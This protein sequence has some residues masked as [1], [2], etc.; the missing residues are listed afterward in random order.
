MRSWTRSIA[1]ALCLRW[2]SRGAIVALLLSAVAVGC[3]TPIAPKAAPLRFESQPEAGTGHM[4]VL[5][6]GPWEEYVTDL[7]PGFTLKPDDAL[8]QAGPTT[9]AMERKLLDML[10]VVARVA[11][12]STSV[13]STRTSTSDAVTDETGKTT[14]TGDVKNETID[15]KEPGTAPD[16]TPTLPGD[17]SAAA[18]DGIEEITGQK[19]ALGA[20]ALAQYNLATALMQEVKLLNRY[21]KDATQRDGYRPYLVRM[22]VSL[23]PSVRNA[24]YDAYSTISFFPPEDA[25]ALAGRQALPAVVPLLV[26]DDME[27]ALT[28]DSAELVRQY[29]LAISALI[30]GFAARGEVEKYT[31][32]LVTTIARDFNSLYSVARQTDNSIRVRMGARL[33]SSRNY[34]MVPQTHNITLLLLA[35][36]SIPPGSD[37]VVEG[38][39]EFVDVT[40]GQPIHGGGLSRVESVVDERLKAFKLDQYVKGTTKSAL[41]DA[42]VANDFPAFDAVLRPVLRQQRADRANAPEKGVR[43]CAAL[44]TPPPAPF[45]AT[46]QSELADARTARRLWNAFNRSAVGARY[47]ST[48]FMLP[49]RCECSLPLPPESSTDATD[50]GNTNLIVDLRPVRNVRAG[51]LAGRL[52]I[53]PLGEAPFTI[54]ASKVEFFREAEVLRCT[55]PSPARVKHG[56]KLV[57]QI[58]LADTPPVVELEVDGSCAACTPCSSGKAERYK[59]ELVTVLKAPPPG[60]AAVKIETLPALR[61][62]GEGCAASLLVNLRRGPSE[63]GKPELKVTF[64]MRA[65]GEDEKTPASGSIKSATVA[66]KEV[67]RK[68]EEAAVNQVVV[69]IPKDADGLAVLV[70]LDQL[71]DMSTLRFAAKVEGAT[72]DP[73]KVDVLVFV[74]KKPCDKCAAP[75]PKKP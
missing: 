3:Q 5:A 12:P 23:M 73:D 10:K 47:T 55:F 64:S 29:A 50:D 45:I 62:C 16:F 1:E 25:S 28:S 20:A 70:N 8:K 24:P 41:D 27:A 52:V 58:L 13:T 31:D 74:D 18:L 33:H 75:E 54:P 67:A 72:G 2:R 53:G 21:V 56:K 66:D 61:I 11:T 51:V 37:V 15:K 40:T 30:R 39:T 6:V 59:V 35:P 26:T 68:S 4:A 7:Q 46:S 57:S 38:F 34:F 14:T 65:I 69:T 60:E 17:K 22:Q 43:S 32:E 19:P 44:P 63:N 71:S 9:A 42:A 36:A 49:K 48:R